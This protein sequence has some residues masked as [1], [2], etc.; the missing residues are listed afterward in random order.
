[1]NDTGLNIPEMLVTLK[2]QQREL[3][4][5]RRIAQMF[6]LGTKE[7]PLPEGFESVTTERGVFHFDPKVV[8]AH[9][10]N[11]FS[12]NRRENLILGLGPYN[13]ADVM[14]RHLK[15]EPLIAVT[16]RAP[17]GIEVK[18]AL[19]THS[20]VAEQVNEFEQSKAPGSYVAIEDIKAV[21]LERLKEL[22]NVPL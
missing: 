14:E 7:L 22:N 2:H 18:A 9:E 5:R 8:S 15:G 21:L 13:K 1:M 3:V 17:N 6:P 4:A 19:G 11:Q 16:E 12:K 20:T 10:I